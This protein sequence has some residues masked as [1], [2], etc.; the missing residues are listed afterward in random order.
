[1]NA[2]P[3]YLP[4]NCNSASVGLINQ[5]AV[6]PFQLTNTLSPSVFG[7]GFNTA[8]GYNTSTTDTLAQTKKEVTQL[9]RQGLITEEEYRNKL[10][11]LSGFA[12]EASATDAVDKDGQIISLFGDELEAARKSS[13]GDYAV[14]QDHQKLA[15][16]M[17]EAAKQA[18]QGGSNASTITQ[19]EEIF[20]MANKNPILADAFLTEAN[21]TTF[22]LEGGK[23]SNILGCYQQI[24]TSVKG[25]DLGAQKT[26]EIRKTL[27]ENV[28]ERN[29]TQWSKFNT[30]YNVDSA[31]VIT[32]DGTEI[33]NFFSDNQGAILGGVA[34]TVGIGCVLAAFD[35]LGTTLKGLGKFG[36]P[37]ALL[38][39]G[40]GYMINKMC[41]NND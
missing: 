20:N 7:T 14:T 38:I 16:N 9:Y 36:I 8:Y 28:S 18:L 40:F 17:V 26:A 32:N 37:A 15:S 35:G 24:V 19:L 33:G 39:G 5:T 21:K 30:S 31:K 41:Q 13:N 6:N 12:A 23:Q 2:L 22:S 4:M 10:R 11:S 34:G 3:N 25:K 29:Q 27:S 1:M